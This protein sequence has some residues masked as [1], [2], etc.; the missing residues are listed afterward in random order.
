MTDL[1]E[2][3]AKEEGAD[4]NGDAA[5]GHN[6]TAFLRGHDE[7]AEAYARRIFCRVFDEDIVKVLSMEVLPCKHRADCLASAA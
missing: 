3:A 7:P 5:D 4:A 1:D 2:A 6:A